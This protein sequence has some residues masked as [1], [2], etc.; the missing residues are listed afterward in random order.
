MSKNTTRNP[1]NSQDL[2]NR[3]IALKLVRSGLPVFP[4]KRDKKP[5]VKG[6]FKAATTDPKQIKAWWKAHP[7]ALPGLPTGAVSGVAVLD[8]DCKNGKDG[9]KALKQ[10]GLHKVAKSSHRPDTPSGG[11]HVYFAHV[12]G[13][14]CSTSKIADG[15]DVRAE[16]GYVVVR[17]PAIP[18]NLKPFPKK[19]HKLAGKREATNAPTPTEPTQPWKVTK[20]ALKAIPNDGRGEDHS[21]DWWVRMLAALHHESGGSEKGLRLAHKW[22]NRHPSADPD[23]TDHAWQSFGHGTSKATGAAITKEAA[24]YGWDDPRILARFHDLDAQLADG[25]AFHCAADLDG[26]PV[27]PRLWHVDGLIPQNTVTSLYGAGGTGKSLLALQL[28]VATASGTP[29]IGQEISDLGDVIYLSAEDDHEELHRRL[30]DVATAAH[31]TLSDLPRLHYRSLV[32]EGAV[33][34]SMN[35]ASKKM[36][37]TDLFRQLD[38]AVAARRPRLLI[39]DTLANLFSGDRNDEGCATQFVDMLRGLC[40][41]HGCSLVLLAHPSLTG[42]Q[43]GTG[44]GGSM[45]WENAVRSRLFLRRIKDGATETNPNA[46]VLET[47]KAN[48]GPTGTQVELHWKEGAFEPLEDGDHDEAL[49]TAEGIFLDCLARKAAQG[50]HV[51]AGGGASYAPSVFAAMA[52]SKGLTKTTLARAM[53]SLFSKEGLKTVEHGPPSKRRRHLEHG[54]SFSDLGEF[55]NG[56]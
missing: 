33:L 36:Q 3:T 27:P 25:L 37:P 29:W 54:F 39:L 12:D 52:E 5:F 21:R 14:R 26:R 24:E 50:V 38:S 42:I 17:D 19:L 28:A 30:S 32:G 55:S 10:A 15:V 46:R 45:A 20:A 49:A 4:C 51:N 8:V 6:G 9:F 40:V 34:A 47:M 48:Y 43:S 23:Q 53:E 44:T 7:S 31:L 11:Q 16:G 1:Y 18:D 35:T 2:D 41:R 56:S 13:L 22:S